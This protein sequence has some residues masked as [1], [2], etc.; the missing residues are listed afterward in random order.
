[1]KDQIL[2]NYLNNM[3]MNKRLGIPWI[4]LADGIYKLG[5]RKI[6][7]KIEKD[8]QIYINNGSGVVHIKEFISQHQ[9]AN[10]SLIKDKKKK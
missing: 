9:I 3:P 6:S 7:I 5:L 1:M 10:S 4:F 2:G 8:N